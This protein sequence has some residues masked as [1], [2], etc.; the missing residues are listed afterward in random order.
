M[1]KALV[2]SGSIGNYVAEELAAQGVPVR[3]LVRSSK[4]NRQWAELGIEQVAGDLAKFE[5]LTPAFQ[6]VDRF[7]SVTPFVENLVELGNNAVEAAKRAGVRHIVRSSALG[8]GETAITVGR[9]HREVEKTLENSGIPYTILQPNTFMQSYFMQ[10]ESIKNS[11][12]F[13]MPQG[14]GKVSLVDVRDIATVAA[15]CLTER[16]HEGKKYVVTGNEALSNDDIAHKLT[17]AL[18]RK[19]SYH[20]VTPQQAEESMTRA[21]VPNW[22]ARALL[23]LFDFC[24]LGYAAEISPAVEQILRR[25]PIAF[26]RFLADNARAF[27]P[28]REIAGVA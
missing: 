12:S 19:I 9:W 23:E 5:S 2:T 26:D 27:R 6:G 25:K 11:D 1:Q 8:A 3:L 24:K 28:E 10:A 7:F 13:Y 21:G 4:P 17:A 22:M 16:G 15:A 14:Q 18:G 20:D